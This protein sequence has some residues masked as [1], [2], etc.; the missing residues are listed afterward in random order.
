MDFSAGPWAG[1]I[2]TSS[3][4][5]RALERHPRRAALAALPAFTVGRR[6]A[7]AAQEAG[8]A[9]IVSA[10]GDADDL[11]RVIL[12]HHVAGGA[13]LLYLAG[14]DRAADV[15]GALAAAG[16][17]AETAVIY[18]A[19]AARELPEAIRKA[20]AT[21]KIDGLLHFSR[22]SAEIYLNCAERAGLL[23]NALR[24]LHYCL[25]AQVAGPLAAAGA[26]TIAVAAQPTEAALLDL[27]EP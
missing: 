24:P 19:V 14:A 17:A 18:R 6:T 25:S 26:K 21:D 13:P 4:A 1:V 12:A 23:D 3:N 8:F 2:M 15:A 5:A 16:V 10:G 11:V 22:R 20:L 9:Q 7:A 27:L